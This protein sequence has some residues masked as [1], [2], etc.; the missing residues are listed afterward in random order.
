MNEILTSNLHK[1]AMSTL[2]FT[3]FFGI[4][5]EEFINAINGSTLGVVAQY[6]IDKGIEFDIEKVRIEDDAMMA[7]YEHIMGV[8]KM[9][10]LAASMGIN[11]NDLKGE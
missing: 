4:N 11:P 2:W 5:N 9:A 10:A 6:Y 3:Q 1:L 7:V 8:A